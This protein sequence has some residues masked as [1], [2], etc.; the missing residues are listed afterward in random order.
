MSAKTSGRIV[1]GLLLLAFLAYGG[2]SALANSV[3]G[4]P[5]VL[6]G[7]VGSENRLIAG[8]LLMLLN[9]AVVVGIG[10]AAYPVL[11]RHHPGTASAYLLTRGFEASLLAVGAV[12]LLTLVPLADALAATGDTVFEPLARVTQEASLNAYWVAMI[13]LSLGSLLFCRALFL[14]RLLPRPIVVW[15][16]GGYALLA[17]GGVLELL[18][19]GVGVPLAVPGGLFEATAGVLLVAKGFPEVQSRDVAP[20]SASVPARLLSPARV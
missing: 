20:S 17:L 1:G 12:L 7:V 10:V 19:Q 11:K 4:T 9:S 14:T 18:G 16:F 5:V 8:V 6:A 2:G 15:G 3:T 13:G